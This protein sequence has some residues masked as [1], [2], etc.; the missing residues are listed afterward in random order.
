MKRC[1][2]LTCLLAIAGMLGCAAPAP[3]DGVAQ[4]SE[5][6][7]TFRVDRYFFATRKPFR[8]FANPLA[9]EL[10]AGGTKLRMGPAYAQFD[11]EEAAGELNA[12]ASRFNELALLKGGARV[13]LLASIDMTY[14]EK[15]VMAP[16]LERGDLEA[17]KAQR[18][19]LRRSLANAIDPDAVY[20][21][22]E[23]RR[24]LATSEFNW[25]DDV[26][27]EGE[28]ANFVPNAALVQHP[29]DADVLRERKFSGRY[30]FVAVPVAQGND[31]ALVTVYGGQ[32]QGDG[33]CA[34]GNLDCVERF[35]D[36]LNDYFEDSSSLPITADMGALIEN[37]DRDAYRFGFVQAHTV[38]LPVGDNGG[39]PMFDWAPC[40][41]GEALLAQAATPHG[42]YPGGNLGIYDI[43]VDGDLQDKGVLDGDWVHV[44]L[45]GEMM[46]TATEDMYGA[47][48]YRT[49]SYPNPLMSRG[50]IYT[51]ANGDVVTD[52]DLSTYVDTPTFDTWA[53]IEYAQTDRDPETPDPVY[54]G[55]AAAFHLSSMQCVPTSE[56]CM[57]RDDGTSTCPRSAIAADAS[58]E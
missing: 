36:T 4:H 46:L 11:S 41:E 51:A 13:E 57:V 1:T 6:A 40:G 12:D 10:V 31:S 19:Q 21:E 25:Q 38:R 24:A 43:G 32:A 16:A 37:Y 33:Q 49:A 58:D 34:S 7:E 22:T 14:F 8:A 56:L 45:P 26:Y 18:D 20:V 15:L 47:H 42:D 39:P 30:Y 35:F 50:G 53:Y 9:G 29:Q 23:Y 52:A 44:V 55:W 17:A 27:G 28:A 2:I 3:T 54:E 5:Q 48:G